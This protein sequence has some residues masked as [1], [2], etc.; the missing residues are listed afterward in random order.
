M[1]CRLPKA[2]KLLQGSFVYIWI[3]KSGCKTLAV[4][5]KY[6]FKV[7]KLKDCKIK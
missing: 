5:G 6:R 3:Y 2:N 7:V 4:L 1:T